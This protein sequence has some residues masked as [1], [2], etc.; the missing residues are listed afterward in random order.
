MTSTVREALIALEMPE[1]RL[2]TER[3]DSV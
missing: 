3:F 2:S 1:Q